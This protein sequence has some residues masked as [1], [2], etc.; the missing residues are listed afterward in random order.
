M[1]FLK[2]LTNSRF[3]LWLQEP[4]AQRMLDRPLFSDIVKTAEKKIQRYDST[5][6]VLPFDRYV[7]GEVDAQTNPDT[8]GFNSK[9]SRGFKYLANCGFAAVLSERYTKNQQ[10]VTL[11]LARSYL[12]DCIHSAS[13][14]TIRILPEGIE[15]KF[16]VYREQ[17]GINFRKANGSSYSAPYAPEESPQNI[18]LGVL[19]DGVTVLMTAE[20]IK[21]YTERL[22]LEN[23]NDFEKIIVADINLD[24]DNLPDDYR[25]KSFHQNVTIPTQRFIDYWGGHELYSQLVR[26]MLTG[27]MREL[28]KYFDLRTGR[29][30][31]WRQLFKSTFY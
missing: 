5:F 22:N 12:H 7:V 20:Y 16:S 9:Y 13:F 11:E 26:A 29:T 18:N 27:K 10:V 24:F 3:D 19:M 15:S 8:G 28:V 17:Y 23:L 30:N 31:S 25:G 2:R 4:S 21:P 1:N 6:Q 14:R